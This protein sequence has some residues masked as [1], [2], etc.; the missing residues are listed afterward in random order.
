MSESSK[1]FLVPLDRSLGL[2]PL[3][4]K[5]QGYHVLICDT[6][7]EDLINTNTEDCCGERRWW[8]TAAWVLSSK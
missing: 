5:D 4:T 2:G 7:T 8:Q 6:G 1:T 3:E